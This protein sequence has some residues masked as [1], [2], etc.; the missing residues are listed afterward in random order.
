[1]RFKIVRREADVAKGVASGL[2]AGLVGT[3]VMSQFQAACNHLV[4]R[5]GHSNDSEDGKN[6]QGDQKSAFA[7]EPEE[8]ATIKAASAL[9]DSLFDQDLTRGEERRVGQ[10][11]HY[12]MG[13][14]SGAIYGVV[15]E[16]AAPATKKAGL[17]FGAAVWLVADE[18][19]IP[20]LGLAKAPTRYPL[21]THAYSF[22]AHLVYGVS[23]EL[24][25]RKVRE[26]F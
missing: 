5:K 18:M 16:Y 23:T 12:A 4:G 20:A 24:A 19:L 25:R 17:Q 3:L 11:L 15:A 14:A 10:A 6:H 1:M 22:A 2:I 7:A 8:P 9:S 21:S 13:A 26:L